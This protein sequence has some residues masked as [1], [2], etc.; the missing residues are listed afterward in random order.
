MEYIARKGEGEAWV[1]IIS[2]RD[3]EGL[4]AYIKLH[5]RFTKTTLQGQTNNR[6]RIRRHIAP[7]HDYEV[8]GAVERWEGRYRMLLEEDGEDEFPERYNM[9]ALKQLLCGD[10]RKHIGLNGQK[11]RT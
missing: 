10:I 2:V 5:Q 4:W 3:G 7:A 11:L 9:S 8:A 1:K 6:W